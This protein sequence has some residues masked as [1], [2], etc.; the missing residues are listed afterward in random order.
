MYKKNRTII[1]WKI[2]NKS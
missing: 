1:L 2:Y